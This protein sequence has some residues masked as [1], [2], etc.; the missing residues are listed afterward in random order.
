MTMFCMQHIRPAVRSDYSR[1][2]EIY[3]FS[4]RLE[5][6]PI[7]KNTDF[8]FNK[9]QVSSYEETLVQRKHEHIYVYD[10]GIIKG[11]MIVTG[12]EILKLHVDYFFQNQSIGSRLLDYSIRRCKA[13]YLW[14][15]KKNQRAI[16]FY[17]RHN[18][19]IT[20]MIRPVDESSEHSELL[21]KMVVKDDKK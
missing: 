6:F 16:H 11:F 3:V 5:Y 7:F 13:T 21:V 10:D 14:T 12:E 20:D 9:L 17:G 4:N 15:L 8:S 18:M 2:A 19:E 1:V